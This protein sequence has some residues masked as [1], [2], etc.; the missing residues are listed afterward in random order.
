MSRE[1]AFEKL[2]AESRKL[3]VYPLIINV[4]EDIVWKSITLKN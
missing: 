3:C 2:A 4:K 1:K